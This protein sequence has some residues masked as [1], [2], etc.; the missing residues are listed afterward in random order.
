MTTGA[1]SPRNV[2]ILISGR[3]SNMAALLKGCGRKDHPAR[4][5]MVVSNRPGAAGLD[6]ARRAGLKTITIDHKAYQD[7]AAFENALD[8]TLETAGID[9]VCLAGFMR[10]LSP[11]FTQRWQG[12]VLNIHPSLLP[13]FKGLNVHQRVV[14][15]GVRIT[16]CTVHLV[17]AEMDAGPILAQAAVPVHPGD[18][19]ESVA[20]RVLAA[21]HRC[22]THALALYAS[23]Q[24][25]LD[26]GK[27]VPSPSLF[28]SSSVDRTWG[29][30]L[31]SP[32]AFDA[33]NDG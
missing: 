14:D 20:E 29:P 27:I 16:G 19:A 21:E 28:E 15:A 6:H 33:R 10:L 11:A 5:A 22:Y 30:P 25:R 12:R 31:L 17:T 32:P 13:S 26:N 18:T 3:G 23:G 4:I 24:L 8:A 7:D 1:K 9:L 2:A